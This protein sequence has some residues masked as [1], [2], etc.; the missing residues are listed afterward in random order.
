LSSNHQLETT[1]YMTPTFTILIKKPNE[2]DSALRISIHYSDLLSTKILLSQLFFTLI[3]ILPPVNGLISPVKSRPAFFSSSAMRLP[4]AIL[5]QISGT[6]IHAPNKIIQ[7]SSPISST[8]SFSALILKTI[9]NAYTLF[10]LCLNHSCRMK[11]NKPGLIKPFR[12]R[13]KPL[14]KWHTDD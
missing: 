10:T 11:R 14:V 8:L 6:Q 12:T 7:K 2:V 5:F 4:I 13:S 9:R 1:I 3:Y